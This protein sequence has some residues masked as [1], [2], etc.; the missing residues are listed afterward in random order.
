MIDRILPG[1]L[2]PGALL[3]ILLFASC[4]AKEPEL[5]LTEENA[6]LDYRAQSWLT[7][8]ASGGD[9]T[10]DPADT[11]DWVTPSKTQ[12]KMGE[13]ISFRVQA[14]L[15]ENTRRA[16]YHVQS[17]SQSREIVLLQ[18]AKPFVPI[19]VSK[20]AYKH[21]VILGVDGA[22]AFFK[23]SYTPNCDAIFQGGAFTYSAQAQKPTISAQNW[24]AILHGVLPE[25]HGLTNGIVASRP[26]PVDSPFPSI[27]RVVREAWPNVAL[28]SFCVWDPV[29][30]GII[31]NNLGI[32][33]G[34]GSD[35]EVTQKTVAYL[36][37]NTP[38]LLFM[39]F[40]LAD[41]AGHGHG[42][43]SPEHLQAI[44]TADGYIGQ[45][46][47]KLKDRGLLDD[48]LFIVCTDHGGTP[49]GSHGGNTQAELDVFLGVAGK[50]VD[51]DTGILDAENR[52][53]AAI[54]AYALGLECPE[55]WTG[56]VPTGVFLGVEAEE[57][58]V[59]ELPVSEY[60]GHETV[61]TP[62]L[63]RLQTLLEGHSVLAYLPM[64]E[65]ASDAFGKVETPTSGKLY[66]YDAYFGKGMAFDDGYVALKDVKVGKGS[67]SAAFWMKT[68][69]V[70][71]DPAIL[72]N[73]DWES[74][75][76]DGFVL[77]L[78]DSD[79]KFNAGKSGARMD[80]TAA[81]PHDYRKGWMHVI[82]VVDRQ[83]DVVRI[84]EDFVL[85]GTG[86]I[87][88]ELKNVS[89]DALD[90]NIGQDGTGHY[91][92]RLAAQLDEFILTADVLTETDVA[93]LKAYYQSP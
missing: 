19:P 64:D 37:K 59:V 55:T 60:R 86:S 72:C 5:Q 49:E 71:T 41:A 57:R 67:F 46:Y 2:L 66:Y 75:A 78:R 77:S 87:P 27:F 93:A 48:T 22:G 24:G 84:Y 16:A 45:I 74:G 43:G 6:V 9:W 63:T 38:T 85:D 15:T 81:L 73:K 58:K 40:D 54:A 17:G 80:V 30:Y 90:L 33:E 68:N 18:E 91:S 51:G 69:G 3:A 39:H 26:Y 61:P 92:A 25:V 88:A 53:I 42:Y 12:G 28:A 11:Y 34:T 7:I 79:I 32:V 31:E 29:N 44:S 23:S 82:L 10:L 21:V 76:N 8:V 65:N 4:V 14:N 1:R 52:D 50:T 83:A 20:G 35:A 89:F 47:A 70:S 62:E 56:R 13:I 36:D